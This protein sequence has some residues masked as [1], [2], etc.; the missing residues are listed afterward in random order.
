M[1]EKLIYKHL[2][3]LSVS[4]TTGKAQVVMLEYVLENWHSPNRNRALSIVITEEEL[5]KRA[6]LL[7]KPN[8]NANLFSN[9][10]RDLE[11]IG[12]FYN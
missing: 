8:S 6:R 12:I 1:L 2:K 10:K 7:P 9:I 5:I 11:A 3:H 4:K